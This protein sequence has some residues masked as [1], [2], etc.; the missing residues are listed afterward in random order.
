M[1][2]QNVVDRPRNS[3]VVTSSLLPKAR[4]KKTYWKN[5][6]VLSSA[7]FFVFTAYMS[8]QN[9][10]SSLNTD[11]DLGVISLTI[12]YGSVVFSCVF[13]AP[14]I[15]RKLGT[16]WTIAGSIVFYTVYTACNYHPSYGT[17]IPS[18]LLIGLAAAPLWTA[19]GTYLTTSA[20]SLA[21]LTNE[22]PE[23]LLNRFNGIFFIIFQSNQVV[24]NLISSLVLQQTNET[25]PNNTDNCGR[26]S[27]VWN[28]NDS[29]S[30][31]H[32][33]PDKDL[34]NTL[35]T[36]Y[37]VLGVIGL[38]LVIFFLDTLPTFQSSRVDGAHFVKKWM[39]T[40][41]MW[42]NPILLLMV[43]LMIYSGVEQAFVAGDYTKAYVTC[44]LGVGYVGYVMIC[45]GVADAVSS[46]L[47]GRLEKHTGRLVLFT[48]GGLAQ[49]GLI[50]AMFFWIPKV[51]DA[52]WKFMVIAA[53]WGFG[54]AVWQTQICSIVGVLF[55]DCQEAAFANFR[56]WQAVGFSIAFASSI[57]NSVC[58]Y[59]KLYGIGGWLVLSMIAY[60]LVEIIVRNEKSG[61]MKV[62]KTDTE[63]KEAG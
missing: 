3:G 31:D 1:D 61:Y 55:P 22:V 46:Y 35:L 40:V 44:G 50:F 36:V 18:S 27:C 59:H 34:V 41:G 24:G 21:D 48:L 37:L 19:Q 42:R 63:S 5:L 51:D 6:L 25:K 32:G 26:C 28:T 7:F 9:L 13:I 30:S 53:G 33:Q 14:I 8:I 15:I 56:M 49:M 10:Q 43:P 47:L 39:E 57:P 4:R 11:K 29:D 45:Y 16:K 38:V 17:L 2:Q 62:A 58:V 52:L 23:P 60:Y 20:I 54:D 12:V